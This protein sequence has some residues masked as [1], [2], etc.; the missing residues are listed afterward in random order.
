MWDLQPWSSLDDTEGF[1]A[2]SKLYGKDAP[3][4]MKRAIRMVGQVTNLPKVKELRDVE[5]ELMKW[6][7]T[8]WLAC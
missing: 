5:R 1:R 7:E 2:W 3:K 6:E 4:T 8:S